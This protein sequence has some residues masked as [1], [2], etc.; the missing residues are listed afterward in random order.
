MKIMPPNNQVKTRVLFGP[1][2]MRFIFVCSP[3]IAPDFS[4]MLIIP[5]KQI[6][7]M[8]NNWKDSLES[9]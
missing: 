3:S 9:T 1:F 2:Q 8:T 7:T 6:D 4:K 5:E